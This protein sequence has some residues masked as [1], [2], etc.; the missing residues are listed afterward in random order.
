M[1]KF[2]DLDN[3]KED[4]FYR[5]PVGNQIIEHLNQ[6]KETAS[7]IVYGYLK[8]N[9]ENSS[10][11][12]TESVAIKKA[13]TTAEDA[14]KEAYPVPNGISNMI[15]LSK[16][17]A[18]QYSKKEREAMQLHIQQVQESDRNLYTGYGI[19]AVVTLLIAI[20]KTWQERRNKSRLA[21]AATLAIEE[22]NQKTEMVDM[23]EEPYGVT[24]TAH[25]YE[26]ATVEQA[27]ATYNYLSLLSKVA[28][29]LMLVLIADNASANNG[30]IVFQINFV[31]I[32]LFILAATITILFGSTTTRRQYVRIPEEPKE[33]PITV[34][35]IK[36]WRENESKGTIESFFE[37]LR[38]YNKQY[39]SE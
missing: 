31:A 14:F 26:W 38:E 7:E 23:I 11:V 15:P 22:E 17:T 13:Q 2:K 20:Y 37:E 29:S 21:A 24:Q 3:I 6:H 28:A 39:G 4:G 10:A 1:K 35:A 30:D 8:G 18:S 36:L 33:K 9:H 34:T 5:F 12:T 25:Q 27:P 32:V 19:F 16:D